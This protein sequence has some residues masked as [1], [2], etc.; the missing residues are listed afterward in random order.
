MQV[1]PDISTPSPAPTAASELAHGSVPPPA[2][3][4]RL[5]GKIPALPKAQR[6]AINRLLHDGA[7]YAAVAERMAEQGVLLN[8]ENISNWF[9]TGFQDY[10]DQLDRLDYQRARYE[11]AA[12][13]LQNTDTARLPEASLQTAAAQIFDLLGRFT[14]AAL[15]QNIANNPD[16]YTRLLNALSRITRESLTLQKYRDACA[17]ARQHLQELKDPK[18]KLTDEERLAIVHQLDEIL[19]L[20][21][22]ASN[23]NVGTDQIQNP[24]TFGSCPPLNVGT[25]GSSASGLH[26]FKPAEQTQTP[27]TPQPGEGTPAPIS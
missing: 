23:A 15:A 18:R 27:E 3:P 13:L 25:N 19:G 5:K 16:Q 26:E 14:P 10:L 2:P 6:D 7:T 17:Q 22:T 20:P 4:R 21:S 12:D 24:K 11:T 8:A 1:S 9:Q